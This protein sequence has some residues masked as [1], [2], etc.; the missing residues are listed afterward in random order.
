VNRYG[1]FCFLSRTALR[2]FFRI[3]VYGAENIPSSGP[4]II[5]P[6]HISFL[7][8]PAAGAFIRREVYYMAR[9]SLFEIP[10]LGR[11]ITWCNAFPVR[12]GSPGPAA[13]RK[14]L[15]VL[16]KGRG[17]LVFPEGKRSSDG[18]LNEGTPG[19]GMLAQ[20]A[21]APVVPAFIRGTDR[22]LPVGALFIRTARISVY[23][24]EPVIPPEKAS[25]EAYRRITEEV[26][27]RIRQKSMEIEKCP[28]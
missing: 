17:L 15:A 22:A 7:D 25:R 20:S 26:M 14:A 11:L 23:Y 10:L 16:K 28:K 13:L 1:F 21:G 19:V 18:K 4:F 8:P 3:E 24:L 9:G 5:A 27:K 6:N 2:V 12:R